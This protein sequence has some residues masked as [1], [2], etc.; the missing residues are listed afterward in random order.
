MASKSTLARGVLLGAGFMYLFDPS[1]GRRRRAI[2]R[3]KAVH[4]RKATGSWLVRAAR[5][6]EH[7]LYGSVL[8]LRAY[9]TS[10]HVPDDVLKERVRARL[11]RYVRH[12]HEVEVSAND[13]RV[14]LRGRVAPGGEA[15]AGGGDE[16]RP[17]RARGRGR[18]E[19]RD[20]TRRRA[21]ARRDPAPDLE[22]GNEAGRRRSGEPRARRGRVQPP[23]PVRRAG[24]GRAQIG[25]ILWKGARSP[26]QRWT[27]IG[28]GPSSGVPRAAEVSL[29]SPRRRSGQGRW[30]GAS[31]PPPRKSSILSGTWVGGGAGN[32]T[33]VRKGFRP[34]R[35][36]LSR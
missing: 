29:R 2:V 32:R 4:L 36:M 24:R 12:A 16:V 33:R 8:T 5:D 27:T 30:S 25:G 21:P 15:A 7:R 17:G 10:A 34:G 28:L 14:T 11:G 6:L 1:A 23:A 3:D 35:S 20:V 26:S 31:D 13:G 22:A 19:A 18:A 9:A